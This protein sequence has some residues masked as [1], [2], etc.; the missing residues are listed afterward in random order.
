[1]NCLICNKL[2]SYNESKYKSY[3]SFYSCNDCKI[4]YSIVDDVIVKL[5]YTHS[6]DIIRFDENIKDVR[7]S[8]WIKGRNF[9]ELPFS[10][11]SSFKTHFINNSLHS[12][13]VKIKVLI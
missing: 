3:D 4:N 9:I 2:L 11:L 7:I 13:I 12:F 8:Q 5:T 6:V 10:F 1:M